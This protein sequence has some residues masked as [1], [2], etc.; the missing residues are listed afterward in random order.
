MLTFK[1]QVSDVGTYNMCFNITDDNP[2]PKYNAYSFSVKVNE[3]IMIDQDNNTSNDS[4]ATPSVFQGVVIP[5]LTANAT[6]Q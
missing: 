5:T 1:P 2:E 4:L 6:K 3:A